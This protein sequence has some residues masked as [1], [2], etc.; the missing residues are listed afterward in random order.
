MSGFGAGF[1]LLPFGGALSFGALPLEAR[2]LTAN[3]VAATP[4]FGD[5]LDP[6][7]LAK[8]WTVTPLEPNGRARLVQAVQ[9]VTEENVGSFELPQI[10]LVTLPCTL[11]YIDGVLSY[12][13]PYRVEFDGAQYDFRALMA[14]ASSAPAGL[15]SDD[16]F[17]WDIANPFLPRDSLVFPPQLGTYQITDAGDL[18]VDRSGESSLRKRIIRRVLSA[19]G[20][21]FHL[22]GYGAGVAIKG[23]ITNDMLRRLATR[24][25]AQVLQEPEVVACVVLLAQ[26]PAAPEVVSCTIKAQTQR[27][28]VQAVV[29]VPLP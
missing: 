2:A 17:I 28:E 29:S 20:S 4:F 7:L 25:K 26:S 1:G 19:A 6:S 5:Q 10:V 21:F 22:Q 27:G 18:G 14:A 15:R 9:L 12:G 8:N 16:G 23:L 11:L 13:Q 24:I 3:V